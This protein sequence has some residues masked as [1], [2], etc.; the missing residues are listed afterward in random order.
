MSKK[1]GGKDYH[2]IPNEELASLAQSGSS[3]ALTTLILKYIPV[4]NSRAAGYYAGG[5]DP[6]DLAQEGMIGLL[7]A[8]RGFDPRKG[9]SFHTFALLCIDRS[10]ISAVRSSLSAQ[11]IPSST[12]LS[13]DSSAGDSISVGELLSDGERNPEDIVISTESLNLIYDKLHRLLSPLETKVFTLY[14]GGC[15]YDTI[16]KRL[17]VSRKAVDNALCRA[18]AKLKT[19]EQNL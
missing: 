8:I 18:K 1:Q 3:S 2:N 13:I 12:I 17:S 6:E 15:G 5:L 7:R 4:V 10:I 9:A 16:A 14:M 19:L 11:K